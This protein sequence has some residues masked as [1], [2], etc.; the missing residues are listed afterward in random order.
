MVGR[1]AEGVYRTLETG[2]GEPHVRRTELLTGPP[3]PDPVSRRSLLCLGHLTDLQLADVQSPARFEY[4][5]RMAGVPG[6]EALVPVQR[7]QEALTPR[8]VDAMVRRLAAYA[9]SPVTGAPLQLVV[10]TGDAIDNVQWNELQLFLALLEG[11]PA[12]PRSGGPAYEG[13]QS[14]DWPDDLFWK[15]DGVGAGGPDLFRRRYGFPSHPGLIE[16]A[17]GEFAAAGLPVPW[18]ACHGNHEAL[19]QGV[20]VVT[21]A[22]AGVLTGDRKPVGPAA[23]VPA[24]DALEIFVT[25]PERFLAGPLRSITPDAGRAPVS[26]REF[27]AAHFRSAGRP[28]GHG[29]TERNRADGTAYYAYDDPSGVRLLALDTAC[30]A[31]LGA[32]ALDPEQLDWVGDRLAEVH[33][34]YLDPAGRVVRTKAEDRLVVLFSHHGLDTLTNQRDPRLVTGPALRRLLHRFP[35][36]VLW[37]NGHTHRNLVLPRPDPGGRTGGFW[38]VTTS[39]IMDWPCQ[40]RVVELIDNRDR[41]LSV[42]CTVLDHDAPPYAE[43]GEPDWLASLHRE[44]AANMPWLGAHQL[45]PGTPADRNVE[46]VLAMPGLD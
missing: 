15:P 34:R 13:V 7:P 17:L 20:G 27:V 23:G 41:T 2:P 25:A 42:L 30:P 8:A 35:N 11:G 45:G 10:T 6:Y 4:L 19:I 33:S 22:V 37:L 28:A 5:N 44:V 31:G 9:G 18:L 12:R 21:G 38:E 24:A 14:L 36:V 16:A 26:R 39:A 43:P 40:A 3:R 29:F 46:L 1:G 32:G